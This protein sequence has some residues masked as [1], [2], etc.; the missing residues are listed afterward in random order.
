M[1]TFTVTDVDACGWVQG[2]EATGA[3]LQAKPQASLGNQVLQY[4]GVWQ[5][6]MFGMRSFPTPL[7]TP[8]PTQVTPAPAATAPPRTPRGAPTRALAGSGGHWGGPQRRRSGM[9]ANR[10]AARFSAKNSKGRN[11]GVARKPRKPGKRVPKGRTQHRPT[12]SVHER[13]TGKSNAL[14]RFAM[15]WLEANLD[16]H[17]YKPNNGVLTGECSALCSRRLG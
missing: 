2:V 10:N 9:F 15:P 14:R 6:G 17:I 11:C 7:H 3:K 8:V 13:W 16:A 4:L 12:G 5:R 1:H